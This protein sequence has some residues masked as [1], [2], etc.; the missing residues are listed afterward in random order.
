MEYS[1]PANLHFLSESLLLAAHLL[2]S[3]PLSA[4]ARVGVEYILYISLNYTK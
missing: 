1:T 4:T 2:L 3:F